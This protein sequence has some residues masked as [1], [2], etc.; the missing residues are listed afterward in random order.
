MTVVVAVGALASLMLEPLVDPVPASLPPRVRV[1]VSGV[2]SSATFSLTRLCEGESWTVPGWRARSFTDS[3]VDTDWAA[4]LNR[5]VTYTLSADGVPV[6]SATVI[7]E[8]ATA[9]I[10]DPIQPDKFLPVFTRGRNPGALTMS[11]DALKAVSYVS[12]STKIPVMGSRYAVG[13]GGQVQAGSDVSAAVVTDDG[14]AAARFRRLRSEAP[15]LLLRPSTDMVPLPP[16]AYLLADVQE[17][18]ATVHIGG[19]LTRWQVTGD[20]V[21]A[22]MQAAISGFVTYDEAQQ[23]LAGVSYSDVQAAYAGLTYLDVQKDPLV[24]AAL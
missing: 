17:Q 22:V 10:Q 14:V 21:A 3:D 23:L 16:L 12:P 8:S 11:S 6:C 24:Y 7:L 5:P 9:I 4:P 1:T 15:I 2:A 13:I 20:L 18:P 19:G